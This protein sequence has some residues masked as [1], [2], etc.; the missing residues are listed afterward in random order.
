MHNK[1]FI[2]MAG[3]AVL[4]LVS[5]TVMAAEGNEMNTMDSHIIIEKPQEEEKSQYM[6][7]TGPITHIEKNGEIYSVMVG[8]MQDGIRFILQEDSLLIDGNQS[9]LMQLDQLREGMNV[10]V[11]IPKNAPMTLSLPAMCGA[12]TAMIVHDASVFVTQGYFDEELV[13][14]KN[15]LALNIEDTTKIISTT[16]EEKTAEDIKNKDAVVIYTTSTRSIPAQTTPHMVLI[17]P[18]PNENQDNIMQQEQ[19]ESEMPILQRVKEDSANDYVLLREQAEELG[20]KLEWDN[21]DK[22]AKLTKGQETI[23]VKVGE[24]VY[25]YNGTKETLE[26]QV[27]LEDGRIY[28]P[29][30]LLE[31]S[32]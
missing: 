27:K 28:V 29:A 14:E 1:R 21:N 22:S 16:G 19:E 4:A 9:T 2:K 10:S 20:Y 15:T 13:N 11:I 23:I 24:A 30:Q 7:K 17:L 26:K 6:T 12:Q 31:K 18:D 25:T 5:T 32:K 8:D 3:I